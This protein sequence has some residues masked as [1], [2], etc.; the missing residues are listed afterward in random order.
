MH[1][2]L[3]PQDPTQGSP[4]FSF[5]QAMLLGHSAW[6]IHSGLQFGGLPIYDDKH[7]QDGE[8]PCAIHWE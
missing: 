7:E 6:T 5:I 2:D 3:N 4:H 8:F 1:W